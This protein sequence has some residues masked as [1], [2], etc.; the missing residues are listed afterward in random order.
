MGVIKPTWSSWSFLVYAGGFTVLGAA[1]AWLQYLNGRSGDAGYAGWAL[2]LYVLLEAV[3]LG[4]QRSGHPVCAGVFAFVAVIGLVAFVSALWHWFGWSTSTSSLSGFHPARLLLELIWLVAAIAALR[5]F[6]FPLLAAQVVLAGWLLVT[7]LISNGGNWSAV[8][9]L[10]IG[11]AYLMIALAVDGGE[12][13][14]Y[15]FWLHVGAGLLVGGSLLWFWHHGNFEWILIA[16]SAL[17][18]VWFAGL[19]G[20][21]SWAVLGAVGLLFAAIHFT[22]EWTHVNVPFFSGGHSSARGWVPPL[23]FTCLGFLLVALGLRTA[24][25]DPEPS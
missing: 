13:R 23:V 10:V 4:F 20:R 22:L 18:F 17:V 5:A 24:R 21:S 16:I 9:T 12:G 19:V 8:V 7:D 6:H 25:R 3:A 11:L 15:G 14:P 1:S 2:L